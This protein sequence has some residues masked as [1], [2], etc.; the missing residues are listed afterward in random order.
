MIIIGILLIIVFGYGLTNVLVSKVN[1]IEKIALG[2]I[3]GIGIFTF[4]WFLMN[5][6]SISYNLIS[7]FSLLIILN[8]IVLVVNKLKFGRWFRKI[9]FDF[10]YF[11]KLDTLEKIILGIIVFLYLSAL[12]QN[13][14]FP[15]RYWDSL[16]LYDFRAKLFAQS[17]FMNTAIAQGYFFGYP[18]LTSLAH[19]FVYVLGGNNPSFIYGLFYL[20]FIVLFSS[21]LK[22]LNLNRIL[23][24]ILTLLVAISPRLF[25]H[26]QWAYT[27]L[28]YTVYIVLG[29]IYLYLGVKNKYFGSFV[30]S[31]IL[32]G[33]STWTR[34]AEPFWLSCVGLAVVASVYLR[35][36]LWPF[37]YTGLVAL[38]MIPWKAFESAFN[39]DTANVI[40]QVA[41]T[42]ST[43]VQNIQLSILKPAFDFFTTNV[44]RMY[45]I[46]F[47][48]LG[49]I[50]L[51]KLITKSRKW[52]FTFLVIINLGLTFAG[53]MVFVKDVSFYQDIPDS[54]ARMVMF[55][56]PMIIYLLGLSFDELNKGKNEK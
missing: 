45:L 12:I 40:G 28:P 49:I 52:F 14:Y 54:L 53:I 4:I 18:L 56:P 16:V 29:S 20:S 1:P 33:L 35:K 7:G 34:S 8:I 9:K 6:I 30:L 13:L 37:V 46:Y 32:I 19:T 2:Y 51:I 3:L 11:K 31:A 41:T 24:F 17:G 10:G 5:L 43:V 23:V 26:T 22:K 50:I 38:I 42:S 48:L 21:N 47:V 36:W 25:D 27:N 44:I 55:L 15:I 39:M